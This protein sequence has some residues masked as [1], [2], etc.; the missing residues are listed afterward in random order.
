MDWLESCCAEENLGVLVDMKLNMTHL[1]ALTAKKASSGCTA[2]RLRD[3]I[4]RRATKTVEGLEE[5]SHKELLRSPGL[6]S[7]EDTEGR[8]HCSYNFLMRGQEQ[9]GT[10]LFSV[11][12][13]DRT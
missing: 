5:D 2:S 7:L 12:T 13:S 1:C 11:E 9:A 10:D 3:S 8:S 6:F 4:L